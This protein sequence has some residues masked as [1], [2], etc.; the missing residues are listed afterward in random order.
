MLDLHA[1]RL[2]GRFIKYILLF[3]FILMYEKKLND[4]FIFGKI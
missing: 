1:L 4:I 2:R 3:I